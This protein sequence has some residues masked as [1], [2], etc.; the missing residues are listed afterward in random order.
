MPSGSP[1]GKSFSAT[2][3]PITAT[4]A[5]AV[6]VDVGQEAALGHPL[7]GQPEAVGVGPHDPPLDLEVEVA[8]RLAELAERRRADDRRDRRDDPVEVVVGQ[9][10]GEDEVV[11]VAA[12]RLLD[13]LDRLDAPEDDVGGPQLGDLPLRLEAGPLGDGQHRD[14]RRDAE[15]QAQDRQEGPHLVQR[16]VADRQRHREEVPSHG[17]GAP[18]DCETRRTL[19]PFS[20]REKV[21]GGAD[22]RLC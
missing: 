9:A 22:E 10:V 6:Q 15:D 5:K 16:E 17:C 1:N 2:S 14:D 3:A 21:P 20:P 12:L 19:I 11:V 13:L 7:A 18:A 4:L 8:H